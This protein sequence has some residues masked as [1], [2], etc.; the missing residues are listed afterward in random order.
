MRRARERRRRR[1]A[2]ISDGEG[3]VKQEDETRNLMDIGRRLIEDHQIDESLIGWW[4]SPLKRQGTRVKRGWIRNIALRVEQTGDDRT[5]WLSRIL[6]S[7]SG[8]C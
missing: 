4:S 8:I 3:I 5:M 1:S 6:L 2:K 7:F